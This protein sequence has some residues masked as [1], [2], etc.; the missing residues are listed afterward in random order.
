MTYK[1]EIIVFLI[2]HIFVPL[3]GL[4]YFLWLI[5]RMKKEEI[6]KPPI[7]DLFI[8]FANYGV[9]ILIILTSLFWHWSAMA[10]LG[11]FYLY[12]LAPIP[13]G[14]IAYRN[15]KRR[16]ISK[17]HKWAYILGLA[18]LIF[19]LAYVFYAKFLY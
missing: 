5:N 9:L 19:I 7:I 17:Y 16:K 1:E 14:I 4:L 2:I 10:S 8:V 13:M 3:A 18:Y 12:L 6:Q 11:T 15:W